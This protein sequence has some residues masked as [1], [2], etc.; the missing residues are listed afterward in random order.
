MTASEAAFPTRIADTLR[1]PSGADTTES[2]EIFSFTIF[3]VFT[4]IMFEFAFIPKSAL[5]W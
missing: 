3:Q 4:Q 1:I 5:L 2:L